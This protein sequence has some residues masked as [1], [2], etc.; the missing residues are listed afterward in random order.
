M[1]IGERIKTQRVAL[2]LTQEDIAK[3]IDVAV[4]TIYKYENGIISNIPI[5][6]IEKLAIVL[7][8]DPQ[9][10]LG[11][12]G[13]GSDEKATTAERLKQLM[14]ERDLKQ[15]DIVNLS[16]P[17]CKQYDIKI[18]RNDISQYLSGKVEPGR[19]KLFILCQALNI[20]EAC[21]MGFDVP[22]EKDKPLGNFLSK[23]LK[24]SDLFEELQSAAQPVK[25]FLEK[26]YT[27]HCAVVI[28]VDGVKVLST[29]MH[30][31]LS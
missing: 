1:T 3:I 23:K 26:Y 27:P 19:N 28:T 6:K 30:T 5:E 15:I 25:E 21:L 16:Q 4:Q 22:M 11:W 31:P 12:N 13:S 24:E 17:F 7:Q 2:G 18:G 14:K 9:W 8:T 29:E 20:N 10:L